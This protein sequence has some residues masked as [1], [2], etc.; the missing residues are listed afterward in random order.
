MDPR[1]EGERW[2]TQASI[3][4]ED[5][6]YLAKGKRHSLACFAAQQAG[7][8]AV[9]AFLYSMGAEAVFGHSVAD[10]CQRAERLDPRFAA[11]ALDAA[12]LDR[13][14]VPTRYPNGLPG[15][16]PGRAFRA[17]DSRESIQAARR[18]LLAVRKALGNAGR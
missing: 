14:Y 3:D 18:V 7:E 12:F 13:F 2:L 5:A 1:A 8:K 6:E 4:L 17:K 9:K 16:I 15:G 10:L 11:S